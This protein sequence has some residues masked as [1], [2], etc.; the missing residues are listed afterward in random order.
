MEHSTAVLTKWKGAIFGAL[1]G[2]VG[3]DQE[4]RQQRDGR[5]AVHQFDASRLPPCD[6]DGLADLN[7]SEE[8]GP[9]QLL[10][11]TPS[12][13]TVAATAAAKNVI[14]V[15]VGYNHQARISLGGSPGDPSDG[16]TI[17]SKIL[18]SVTNANIAFSTSAI[19]LEM[20]LSWMG[21]VDYSYPVDEDMDRALDEIVAV[22]DGNADELARIKAQYQADF[23]SLWIDSNVTGGVARVLTSAAGRNSAYSVVRAKNPTATFV[24]EV[25]HNMGC[26]HLR[27][28]YS[29]IPSSWAP[30]A[31]AHSFYGTDGQNYVTVM[32]STADESR[33]NATRV[34]R[35]SNPNLLYQGRQTGVINVADSARHLQE[36]RQI[37]EDFQPSPIKEVKIT[38]S[39]SQTQITLGRGF[40]A[41]RY[42]LWRT[43]DFS[44]WSRLGEITTGSTGEAARNDGTA[45]ALPKAFYRWQAEP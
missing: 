36:I 13:A 10:P 9:S 40:V 5:I 3:G 22:A 20:R 35:F 19:N 31:F 27:D 14:D 26:R 42:S 18:T 32:G 4:W 33:L 8:K 34:L 21:L 23:A 12:A 6:A 15:V 37:L 11:M 39:G 25:G 24:H 7:P 2:V 30:Y 45:G 17:E 29:T 43:L 38:R 44:T 41:E 1:T 16:A 28:T